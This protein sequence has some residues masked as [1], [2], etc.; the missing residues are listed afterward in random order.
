MYKVLIFNPSTPSFVTA[1]DYIYIDESDVE[2]FCELRQSLLSGLDLDGDWLC[3][4]LLSLVSG[5][6]S[7]VDENVCVVSRL[8]GRKT[9][10]GNDFSY[11]YLNTWGYPYVFKFFDAWFDLVW[12]DDGGVLRRITKLKAAN[13][14]I[15][16]R[17]ITM[18]MGE[19]GVIQFSDTGIGSL[20]YLPDIVFDSWDDVSVD[21]MSPYFGHTYSHILQEFVG[22]IVADG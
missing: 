11:E 6:E 20:A 2:E 5:N 16:D 14:T 1:E 12:L 10:C 8:A 4:S 22:H 18:T 7:D 17:P 3:K 15:D 21:M 13:I 9:I 19:P